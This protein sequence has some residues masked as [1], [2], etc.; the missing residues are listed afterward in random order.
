MGR[1]SIATLIFVL[2][3]VFAGG[4]Q[5]L[6]RQPGPE[7]AGYADI[8]PAQLREVLAALARSHE[9]KMQLAFYV[10][11]PWGG[12]DA[13]FRD[14]FSNMSTAQG[15]LDQEIH[16]WAKGHTIDLTFRFG[17]DVPDQAQAT[18]EARQ[19][20]VIMGDNRTDLTRDTLVQMSMDYEW[21]V[22]LLQTLL[23]K[24]RD[25]GLKAYV[26]HSLKVHTEGS[27]ELARQ[28]K[29]FKWS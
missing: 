10:S 2:V 27:A 1:A 18:M 12:V 28:L 20:K 16:A 21:Q 8:S 15:Q 13:P 9:Q 3:A 23:P 19:Q 17:P 24:V 29:K 22:S 26:E 4:C 14:F 6:P 5:E 7:A 25:P 11:L